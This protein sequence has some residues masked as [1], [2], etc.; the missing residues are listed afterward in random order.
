MLYRLLWIYSRLVFRLYCRHLVVNKPELLQSRGPLLLAAN[1]P[2]SFLDAIILDTL[3][4]RPVWS[5]ARGD[6][7]RNNIA[8]RILNA[9]KIM[10][11]YRVSE[12]VENLSTNY[13]T[14]SDCVELFRRGGI[15]LI[16]SEGKCI[17]EWRLR[18]LKKG[19][20]RLAISCWEKQ[21]PL[22]VLPVGFNY[23]SFRRFGKNVFINFGTPFGDDTIKGLDTDGA[24]TQAFNRRLNSD[25]KEMVYDVDSIGEEK[26]QEKISIRISPFIKALLLLPALIGYIAIAPLYLLVNFIC[27]MRF[28]ESDHYDSVQFT[29]L[30]FGFPLYVLI[31]SVVTGSIFGW[32]WALAVLIGLPC[33]AWAVLHSRER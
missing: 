12:G 29:L 30:L 15:V 20:A 27:D 6:V 32:A 7:F 4:K 16:F 26:L 28:R 21:I 25:L 8:R 2:N 24:K 31:A 19:T 18:P 23:S 5:L 1:H 17:N 10:P 33:T 3:F 13:E 11:V 9:L 14:F 22:Q